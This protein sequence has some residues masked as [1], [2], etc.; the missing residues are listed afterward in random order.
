MKTMKAAETG[1]ADSPQNPPLK[2]ILKT[3]AASSH[4]AD[5][6]FFVPAGMMAGV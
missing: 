3:T 4:P 2:S 6:E 5:S 1:V